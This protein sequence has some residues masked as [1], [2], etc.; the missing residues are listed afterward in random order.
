MKSGDLGYF[1]EEGFLYVIDRFKHLIKSKDG[2]RVTPAE[3]EIII[4]EM[5]GVLQSCV[6]GVED[7][8]TFIDFIYAFVIKRPTCTDLTEKDVMN[9]V[10][11]RVCDAKKVSGV[12]FVDKFPM[13]QSMKI[14]NRELREVARKYHEENVV[15]C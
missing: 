2:Y 8:E 1:D 15:K 11:E 14:I 12:I 3:I 7:K 5:D 6:V 10:N 9:Y 4:D 13:T